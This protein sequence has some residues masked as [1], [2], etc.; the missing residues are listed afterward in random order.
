M[1]NYERITHMSVNE[2]AKWIDEHGAFDNSPWM[3]WFDCRY[4]KRCPNVMCKSA[5][6]SRI[7]PCSYCEVYDSCRF[8]Q[9]LDDV[10]DNKMIIKMWL[11][12]DAD[13]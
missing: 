9:D 2:M 6:D 12:S 11:E 3:S 10:P 5:D 13:E 8:F 7:F 1:T 4:W